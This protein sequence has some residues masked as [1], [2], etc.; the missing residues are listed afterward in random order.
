MDAIVCSRPGELQLIQADVPQP[1]NHQ[2]LLKIHQVGICG[3]DLHAYEGTQPF[4]SYP[5]ILG[6]EL[7]AELLQIPT[8]HGFAVGD[9]VTVKPYFHC[10]KC[11][12]CRQGKTNCCVH[13]QVY[14]VHVDG[15]MRN[16]VVLPISSLVAGKGLDL[17]QL[18][19]VEPLAIGAHGVRRAG[20]QSGEYVLIVGA[21]PIGIG[22]TFLAHAAGAHVILMDINSEKLA[23]CRAMISGLTTIDAKDANVEQLLRDYTQGDMPN[24][25]IDCTGSQKAINQA[26]HYLAHAGRFVLIGLQQY[27]VTFGHPEFHK[28][29]ATLMS[30]RNAT[31]EDFDYVIRLLQQAI[32]PPTAFI[33]HRIPHVQL[34]IVFDSLL[35]PTS[36]LIKATV[37]FT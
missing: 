31:K 3:T 33:T 4:F 24:V 6:H 1:A 37:N 30:S 23:H 8:G 32:I 11:V 22:A 10:G 25:I 28:R 26:F 35:N 21:G 16:Q 29:E 12:A 2:A 9:L 18:T 20:I 5:R 34:P 36:N 15:G 27:P 17:D 13:M 19:L 14:G 7:A